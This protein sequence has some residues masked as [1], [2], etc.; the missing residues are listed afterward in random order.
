MS[1]REQ[2]ETLASIESAITDLVTATENSGE[3]SKKAHETLLAL[4]SALSD[5]SDALE[6]SGIAAALNGV[7]EAIGSFKQEVIVNVPQQVAPSVNV[8][9]SPT[10]ITFEAVMPEMKPIIHLIEKEEKEPKN[11]EWEI[12]FPGAGGYERKMTIKRKEV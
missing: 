7:V 9:V 6:K 8:Q 1:L 5:I 3:L 12:T 10:P 11:I 4:E 2:L